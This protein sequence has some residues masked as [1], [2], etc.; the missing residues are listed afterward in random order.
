MSTAEDVDEGRRE[1][2]KLINR[3]CIY[4]ENKKK[5]KE[6]LLKDACDNLYE[7]GYVAEGFYEDVIHRENIGI[8]AIGNG[9][10]IPHGT[11]ANVC[12]P[13]VCIIKTKDMV[14]WGEEQIDLIFL[15]A[16]NFD[17]VSTTKAFFSDFSR[18]ID[19]REKMDAI[20][21][22]DTPERIE[23]LLKDKLYWKDM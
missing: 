10:A 11:S 9:I 14:E 22:A 19:S 1:L 21:K 4:I 17:N 18:M 7:M 23:M 12:K 5:S 13:V 2:V 20:R 15:L 3:K 16:L 8:T 6:K